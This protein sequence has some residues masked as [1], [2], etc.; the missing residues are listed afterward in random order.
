MSLYFFA[1]SA[2][3]FFALE[4]II[5]KLISK[6]SIPNPWLFNFLWAFFI[7]IFTIPIALFFGAGFPIYLH[8]I[9]FS[10][11]FFA[12][13][14]I[15]NTISLYK[16]DISVFIP[17]FSFRTVMAVIIGSIFLNEILTTHQY[18]LIIIIFIF[19]IFVSIDENF[20][21]SSFFNWNILIA[22]ACM[23]CYVI[24]SVFIKKAVAIEGFWT[25]MLWI[26]IFCQFW[27][28][29]TIPFFRK[30]ISLISSKQYSD[31]VVLSI[32]GTLGTLTI[33]AAFAKNV[34]ITTAIESLPL[35]MFIAFLFSVFAPELLEKHTLKV[36]LIRFIAA[37][38]M[39]IAALNL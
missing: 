26:A 32:L 5:A 9:F 19:G 6:H 4:A 7:L 31:I 18:F 22:L 21:L 28:L 12:L 13:A 11:I 27:L 33:N 10:S 15:L 1:W 39:I 25:A 24:S 14:T 17:L 35:S 36:Y 20:S 30:S 29:F 23:F 38:V 34:S 3:I 37:G 16:L 2:S 8:Y